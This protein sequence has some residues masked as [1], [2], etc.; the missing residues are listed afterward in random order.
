ML[1]ISRESKVVEALLYDAWRQGLTL[2]VDSRNFSF[3]HEWLENIETTNNMSVRVL[4]LACYLSE[5]NCCEND[6]ICMPIKMY[7]RSI[8]NRGLVIFFTDIYKFFFVEK[9]LVMELLTLCIQ[10]NTH[11]SLFA[12]HLDNEYMER[13]VYLGRLPYYYFWNDLILRYEKNL[14]IMTFCREKNPRFPAQSALMISEKRHDFAV[15]LSSN[16]ATFLLYTIVWSILDDVYHKKILN[17]ENIYQHTLPTPFALYT[18]TKFLMDNHV[19]VD[20]RNYSMIGHVTNLFQDKYFN[21][22]DSIFLHEFVLNRKVGEQT[23]GL[24]NVT[25]KDLEVDMPRPQINLW[26]EL[27]F[28]CAEIFR[29]LVNEV[30]HHDIEKLA[31]EKQRVLHK[32][33]NVSQQQRGPQFGAKL[34]LFKDNT[35]Y[36]G[37]SSSPIGARL[38]ATSS[39]FIESLRA[40]VPQIFS[41]SCGVLHSSFRKVFNSIFGTVYNTYNLKFSQDSHVINNDNNTSELPPKRDVLLVSCLTDP[42]CSSEKQVRIRCLSVYKNYKQHNSADA[43]WCFTIGAFSLLNTSNPQEL[44]VC[45]K[46]METREVLFKIEMLASGIS[47]LDILTTI[48]FYVHRL[49]FF[50]IDQILFHYDNTEGIVTCLAPVG[51]LNRILCYVPLWLHYLQFEPKGYI[52]SPFLYRSY[53][54]SIRH[55][56]FAGMLSVA[57]II[58]VQCGGYPKS[59]L[60]CCLPTSM[61]HA[62]GDIHS[63]STFVE[64]GDYFRIHL[65]LLSKFIEIV[66][67]SDLIILAYKEMNALLK[68]MSPNETL[69]DKPKDSLKEYPYEVPTIFSAVRAFLD[70][71]EPKIVPLVLMQRIIGL[72]LNRN[73]STGGA[74]DD[75]IQFFVEYCS[76]LL[77]DSNNSLLKDNR[78]GEVWINLGK[79]YDHAAFNRVSALQYESLG[80]DDMYFNSLR[81]ERMNKFKFSSSY[82]L[83]NPNYQKYAHIPLTFFYYRLIFTLMSLN[84]SDESPDPKWLVTSF[85]STRRYLELKGCLA[86]PTDTFSTKLDDDNTT[87]HPS[88]P[89][90]KKMLFDICELDHISVFEICKEIFETNE[91]D[92]STTNSEAESGFYDFLSI[93]EITS[94]CNVDP[95]KKT[96]HVDRRHDLCQIGRAEI[97]LAQ[98][99]NIIF[100]LPSAG[101]FNYTELTKDMWKDGLECL[102]R[103]ALGVYKLVRRGMYTN[104]DH[105]SRSV[106]DVYKFFPFVLHQNINQ[107]ITSEFNYENIWCGDKPEV[108]ISLL[109]C[110]VSSCPVYGFKWNG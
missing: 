73:L 78:T 23:T 49:P 14:D 58:Y 86:N 59:L 60:T 31:K 17:D 18:W 70:V 41:M 13:K 71:E 95:Q 39:E 7:N 40:A 1:T 35:G 47:A 38:L 24:V 52:L 42:C 94:H 5:A 33:L 80:K 102:W 46:T 25:L 63:M 9:S 43:R 53:L 29:E 56:D 11:P 61:Q 22:D 34:L 87:L 99:E 98:I 3:L 105:K 51:S 97:T 72:Y 2:M 101:L 81:T 68:M 110:P 82:P 88:N 27:A 6:Q 28:C 84:D 15:S 12:R 65:K 91:R 79:R 21:I 90:P 19:E 100:K 54:L 77:L 50:H 48:D 109:L 69:P 93:L 62:P 103:N 75:A 8:K 45:L 64:I 74:E 107:D 30:Y 20:K 36:P 57:E 66:R 104:I 26:A 16:S 10:H 4:K 92:Y 67:G 44:N 32:T 89:L 96:S 76:V 108:P 85:L 83:G 106:P 55:N 37:L